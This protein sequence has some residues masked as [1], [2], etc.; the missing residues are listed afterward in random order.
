MHTLSDGWG[1]S[2]GLVSMGWI[3][4]GL[5]WFVAFDSLGWLSSSSARWF[6]SLCRS[7]VLG[8]IAL[9]AALLITTPTAS[10]SCARLEDRIT[11]LCIEDPH[12]LGRCQ[13]I[14]QLKSDNKD[15]GM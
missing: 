6:L 5:A 1:Q 3:V 8:T 9:P 13:F 14:K 4:G 15:Q 7:M 11:R 10:S 12:Q 2:V